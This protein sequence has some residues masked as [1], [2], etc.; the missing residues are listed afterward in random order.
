M[1]FLRKVL[2]SSLAEL[3]CRSRQE[4]SKRLEQGHTSDR[5]WSPPAG[6][7]ETAVE[8][9]H[10]GREARFFPGALRKSGLARLRGEEPSRAVEI[11]SAADRL[12]EQR[13]DLLGYSDLFFGN[14]V[15]W[16][17]D[18]VSG[19]RSPGEH[20]SRIR[21]L[22]SSVVGDSKVIWELNRHQWMVTLGQAYRLDRAERYAEA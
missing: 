10:L 22:D 18:A 2:N 13:F 12:L 6:E 3:L 4:V 15:D 17:L 20:W 9:F 11:V 16:H 7:L 1:P 5:H 14:P 21:F 8:A 19:R